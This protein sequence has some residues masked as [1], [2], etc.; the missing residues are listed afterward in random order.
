MPELRQSSGGRPVRY[1]D[2]MDAL[3]GLDQELEQATPHYRR[4][5]KKGRYRRLFQRRN[6][7]SGQPL[8]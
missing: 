3:R 7:N 1:D 4:V 8:Q 6:N 2:I 5:L